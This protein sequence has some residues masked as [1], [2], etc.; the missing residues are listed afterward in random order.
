MYDTIIDQNAQLRG[1]NPNWIKAII[2]QESSWNFSAIRYE[3]SYSYLCQPEVFAKKIGVTLETETQSQKFSW[4]LGQIMGALAREQGLE[5]PM[6]Q[7]V[8][9]AINIQ[10]IAIRLNVLNKAAMKINPNNLIVMNNVFAAYNAGP[11][12]MNSK[13]TDYSNQHYVDSVKKYLQK[14]EIKS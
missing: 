3:P 13:G 5:G 10:H 2:D 11:G 7:L 14:Y 12:V 8:Q 6:P 4:G 1:I 9:P